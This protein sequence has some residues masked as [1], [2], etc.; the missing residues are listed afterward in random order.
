LVDLDGDGKQDI[1][2]GSWP[3]RITLF[4]R[5][6]D[7]F[8]GGETLSHAD[9][10]PINP[11]NG[12]QVF[13]FDWDGDGK[14]DLII[15]TAGG[16]VLFAPNVG[17][18]T[19]PAFGEAKPLSAGGKPISIRYGDAAP[20]VA[21]WDGD[22]KPDLVVGGGDGSVVWFRNEGT[23]REAKLAAAKVLV[24]PSP[25]PW[26]DDKARR[27]GEWGVRARPAV[28]D[29]N[30]DGKLDLL[31][32]DLCGGFEATP[33]S[34]VGEKDELKDA[35]EQ[36]PALR[37]EWA[38][39]YKSFDELSDTA[40]S[41]DPVARELQRKQLARLRTQVTRLKDEITRLQDIRD[42]H[43]NRYMSHGYV[44]LFLRIAPEK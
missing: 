22:G 43:A 15:G 23:R 36:L 6:G 10:K 30:G 1:I 29:W 37:K 33:R 24:P 9:G 21:D 4:R 19:K 14:L 35:T 11:A 25:S 3:G 7:R 39:A 18:R 41:T 44:W 40:E 34:T 32:G 16:E 5:E 2:S 28:V 20:V 12:S 31:I 42:R 13:A 27:P 38:A 17:T 8:A 26:S